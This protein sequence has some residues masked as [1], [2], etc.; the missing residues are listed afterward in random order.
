MRGGVICC[1]GVRGLWNRGMPLIRPV[2]HLLPVM[3]GRRES[4]ER[5]AMVVRASANNLGR[6][7][8]SGRQVHSD[9]RCDSFDGRLKRRKISCDD[10]PCQFDVDSEI[11][12]RQH[13]PHAGHG[14]PRDVRL[15]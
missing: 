15:T 7:P 8:S 9:L 1:D 13:V 12:M 11:S 10:L 2:G 4:I 5:D 3:T 14:F 6:T